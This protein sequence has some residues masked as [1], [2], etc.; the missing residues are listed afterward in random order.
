VS[1]RSSLAPTIFVLAAFSA[2]F[3]TLAVGAYTQ[4]SAT[5]DEP[6]HL[7][8]GYVALTKHDFR[9]DPS[10][11]PFLRMWAALPLLFLDNVSISDVPADRIP[12]RQWLGDAYG[13]AHR[14]LY[15]D[16]DADRLLYI[17]RFMPVA[18][19]VVLGILIFL[20][21]REW[22]GFTPAVIALACY[23]FEPNLLAHASLVT[24]DLG[25]T[26]FIFGTI[27][28]AWLTSR[29]FSYQ[30]V[31]GL[32]LCFSL[33][34]VSKF[35]AVLLVPVVLALAL[36]G[37]RGRTL[38]SSRRALTIAAALAAVS[39]AVVWASY[40]FS[41]LPAESMSSAMNFYDLAVG[42]GDSM[43]A[44]VVQWID[45]H[46]LL[47]NG[48]AQG[49]LYSYTSALQLPAFLSGSYSNEGWWYYF[50]IAFVLKTPTVLILLVV[51][52]V[53]A[54]CRRRHDLQ[55]E[56]VGFVLL[57]VLVFLGVAMWSGINIGLRHILPV[58]PFVILF[59]ALGA[60]ELTRIPRLPRTAAIAAAITLWTVEYATAYPYTLTFFNSPA[61][62]PERGYRHLADSNLG[63]G[64]GLKP[65]KSWMDENRVTH[66]NLAYFGQ[67]DP[68]YYGIDCTHLPGAP[69]FATQ[70]IARPRLPGFVAISATTLTGVYAPAPWRLFYTGFRDLQPV[71]IIGNS[72]RVYWIERW[73][74]TA[75]HE[76][77]AAN[78]D[79]ERS[80]GDALWFGF[81]WPEHALLHYQRYLAAQPRD[82]SVLVNYGGALVAV[83]QVD[84]GVAAL[85]RAVNADGNHV[86]ARVTLG[87][88]LLASRDLRGAAEH[89]ERAVALNPHSAEAHLLIG[90][91][92]AIQG[93]FEDAARDFARVIEID[94]EQA[95]AREYLRRFARMRSAEVQLQ[96]ESEAGVR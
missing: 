5:W 3:V 8:A 80:L 91:V 58:Y 25:V 39:V 82:V 77:S 14:F 32:V 46:R 16:N 11:P 54:V 93:R 30:R 45:T 75:G 64:Q 29:R 6:I 88:V 81:E 41:Y 62:G 47:P 66:V 43:I 26:C 49:F 92:H 95:D 48:Y 78:L 59:A 65:L 69:S 17:A 4:S 22:L 53:V 10:H 74:E 1:R 76:V 73:P 71:A 9:V 87:K 85:R 42:N 86:L 70:A 56:D 38:M 40:G 37:A 79:A 44:A 83:N 35:S 60:R 18:L 24:T 67:A 50:L 57:P 61:G 63:W 20:W 2:L 12:T 94:P 19:G 51:A 7:T 13:F 96:K 15:V 27:Y 89:A 21:T 52:G 31:T 23:T 34:L 72:I 55:R 36:A 90:R 33:A 28:F 68:A 84:E